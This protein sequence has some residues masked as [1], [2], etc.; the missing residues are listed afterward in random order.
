MAV[1]GTTQLSAEV[2]PLYDAEYY[3][4]GQSMVYW[5]QFCDLRE[6]MNGQRGRS[7]NFPLIASNQPTTGVLSETDDVVAQAMRAN[8]IVVTLFEYGG[9]VEITRLLAATSYADVYEQAAFVNGYNMAESF[10]LI[11]RQVAGQG[12]RQYMQNNRATRS[13][14][15]GQATAAD[16]ITPG[17]LDR[18]HM[19]GRVLKMPLYDDGSLCTVIHPFL[20]YDLIQNTSIRDLAIRQ[21]PEML[22]NGEVAYWGGIRIIVTPAAKV[23]WGAGANDAIALN[24]TS[25]ATVNVGDNTITPAS[26][27]AL[28]VGEMI[29]IQDGQEPG[30][31]WFDTNEEMVVTAINGNVVT[32]YCIDPG[33]GDNGGFRYAHS[34]GVTVTT[35]NSVYPICLVGPNSLTKAASSHT[36]P[37]GQTVVSGP[38]DTLGRFL[39]FGW[40]AI[41]GFTR[42]QSGWIL[43]GECGSATA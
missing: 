3:M 37:Y 35:K 6:V 23:F 2:V 19:M 15:D 12:G 38:F 9:A 1:T 17:F 13:L 14:F 40:Y 25:T 28:V 5:D 26:V 7:Y 8:E 31:T 27:S 4:Q 43:R 16:R 30:N 39:K 18:L 21:A 29:S 10:D 22:F 36:G 34:S 20:M 41:V 33:P 24:T 11:V 42:T 32:G